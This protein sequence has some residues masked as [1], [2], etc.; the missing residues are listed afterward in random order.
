M[1][2]PLHDI[3]KIGIRDSILQKAGPLTAEEFQIMK[4]HTV[5]G[6]AILETIAEMAPAIPLVRSHHERWDGRGYPDG[7]AGADIPRMARIVAVADTFDAMTSD[8]PYRTGM[9]ARKAFKE[10][11]TQAGKQF[12]PECAA[13]FL[14]LEDE[15]VRVIESHTLRMN[16]TAPI[17]R[18]VGVVA[19]AR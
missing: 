12:D 15:L 6:V 1:G 10:I 3:G 5:K 18:P 17:P 14:A 4:T 11:E 2:T 16:G 13:A 7:L 8:R 19:V 9:P